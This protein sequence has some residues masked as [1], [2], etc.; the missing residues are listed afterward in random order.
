M[1][2]SEKNI[3]RWQENTK[4]KSR[5]REKNKEHKYL[6]GSATGLYLRA[7]TEQNLLLLSSTKHKNI[8]QKTQTQNM[9][10]TPL[11]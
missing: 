4:R 3:V 8:S 7:K 9:L 6:C 10:D 1:T 11:H 2:K 5:K